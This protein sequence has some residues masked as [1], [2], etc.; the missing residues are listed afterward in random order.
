MEAAGEKREGGEAA[1]CLQAGKPLPE[2][3][4]EKEEEVLHLAKRRKVLCSEFAAITS[5]DAAVARSF[6]AGSGWHMERALNAYFE[7]PLEEKEEEE[8]AAGG[9]G[10]NCIDL[11]ADAATTSNAGVN[12][13]D[14]R[15]QEDDS[16][17]SLITWNID[18]LDLGSLKERA[19]G[20]CSYLA[21]YSPDVVFLQEVILPQ[22][23][24]LQVRAGSYAIIPG[25][26][27]GYFTAIM[28]KKSRVKL[29]KQEIIPFPT[30][31]MMRNLLVVHVSISGNE[32]CLMTSHL[33]STK[34]HSK[35]RMKQ[36]QIV[37]DKMQKESESTT[38]IF[39]GDTN[40]RDNEVTK[41]GGLP[42]NILDIWEF[43]GKPQHCRYT[44]DT[45][46]NTNLRAEYKCK[47]RFDRV[48]IRPAV[49]GGHIIPRSMD[50]IGLEKLECGR[51][52]S[53]HW[54]LLCN[55]DVVL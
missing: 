30:T 49:E 26:V 13:A 23:S 28:L 8:G 32:L 24:L 29:L 9:G 21:L 54:G 25:A 53:D 11:T 50:L 17:F 20:I 40:L 22:L 7:P 44:W 16:S 38:V 14:S 55:F 47:M 6:L 12:S 3:E 31:A 35:E 51:F 36:L 48:Y 37:L 42:N 41:L 34:N 2:E 45:H 52:A 5:S 10:V 15:Q 33:E 18:G 4:E 27:D 1:R 43:L 19:G 39:G 46:S